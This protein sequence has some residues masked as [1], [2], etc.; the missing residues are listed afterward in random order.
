M[1]NAIVLTFFFI[2]SCSTNQYNYRFPSSSLDN[3]KKNCTTLI[4][5][6][7]KPR[8]IASSKEFFSNIDFHTFIASPQERAQYMSHSASGRAHLN[9]RH[10]ENIRKLKIS[11]GKLNVSDLENVLEPEEIAAVVGYQGSGAI[12]IN[13]PLRSGDHEKLTKWRLDILVLASALNKLPDYSGTVYRHANLP[14][15]KFKNLKEGEVIVEEAFTS[16]STMKAYAEN[17]ANISEARYSVLYQIQSHSSKDITQIHSDSEGEVLFR[18]FTN[19]QI[20]S[21]KKEGKTYVV[22]MDEI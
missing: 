11:R 9:L 15:A 12:G 16:T 20:Q 17:R 19:F 6:F 5:Y 10:Y 3:Y 7:F 14:K 18:P 1:K 2:I 8:P 4:S 21:I 22:I 13:S